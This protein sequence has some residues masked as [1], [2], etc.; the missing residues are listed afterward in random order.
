[1]TKK[2]NDNAFYEW[3]DSIA[4][5]KAQDWTVAPLKALDDDVVY[6]QMLND[7]TYSYQAF[8]E[9]NPLAANLMLMA[10][11][12]AHFDDSGKTMYRPTF[13]NE[14]LFSGYPNE[15]NPLGIEG[16]SWSNDGT[17]YSPSPSQLANYFNY[18]RTRD[19]LDRAESRPVK[20]AM[21]EYTGGKGETNP[22]YR[23]A[24]KVGPILYKEIW[25]RDIENADIFFNHALHQ[26]AGESDYGRSSVAKKYNN[27]GGVM[28]GK[29]Y[30]RYKDVSQF[31]KEYVDMMEG[32]YQQ[33][34]AAKT[35]R[36]YIKALTKNK[37][38]H[39][40]FD[41]DQD[42][43]EQTYLSYLTSAKTFDKNFQRFKSENMHLFT[44]PTGVVNGN[45]QQPVPVQQPITI[46]LQPAPDTMGVI[47]VPIEPPTGQLV[48]P[49]EIPFRP[50]L[51]IPQMNNIR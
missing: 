12:A 8:Y 6:T 48:Q 13:S 18:Q 11:G 47:K 35:A 30:K 34:I 16:G 51:N 36:D 23:F 5:K 25:S 3:L 22:Y 21:P 28:S 37:N 27:L 7:P 4:A 50:T 41:K 49:M 33:A 46:P 24:E 40:Y 14:S 29:N 10:D 38:G 42:G 17:V 39:S 9:N 19:Y 32:S 45:L 20:I 44:P 43:A 26:L 2:Q 1:M 15:Y 31:I